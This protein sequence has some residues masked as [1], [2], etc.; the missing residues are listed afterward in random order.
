MLVSLKNFPCRMAEE[1]ELLVALHDAAA[2]RQLTEHYAVR[3]ASAGL[4]QDVDHVN[5]MNVLFTVLPYRYR[6]TPPATGLSHAYAFPF[7]NRVSSL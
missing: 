5:N 6:D 2:A 3:W 4:P 7:Y 1:A